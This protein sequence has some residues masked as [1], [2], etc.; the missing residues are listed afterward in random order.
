LVTDPP[1]VSGNDAD[2]Y[3]T[4]QRRSFL[5]QRFS[6]HRANFGWVHSPAKV[7][8]AFNGF[9]CPLNAELH[10]GLDASFAKG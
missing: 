4:R 3:A 6:R 10:G 7:G 2:A 9:Q 1:I 5:S 8:V